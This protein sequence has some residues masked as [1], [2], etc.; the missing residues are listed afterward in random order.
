ML[1]DPKVSLQT[2]P[3]IITQSSDY[4]N[5]QCLHLAHKSSIYKRFTV[6]TAA[7]QTVPLIDS[8]S[9]SPVE[10]RLMHYASNAGLNPS[11]LVTTHT[12]IEPCLPHSSSGCHALAA[13]PGSPPP[14]RC[15]WEWLLRWHHPALN[16]SQGAR[17][18]QACDARLLQVGGCR[19]SP[20]EEDRD[21][22][23]PSPPVL[24]CAC[25]HGDRS[26]LERQRCF[27]KA[28]RETILLGYLSGTLTGFGSCSEDQQHP[29]VHFCATLRGIGDYPATRLRSAGAGQFKEAN[30]HLLFP[31]SP[32]VLPDGGKSRSALTTQLCFSTYQQYK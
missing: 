12:S 20:A 29:S 28:V 6:L 16:R 31:C 2:L 30:F 24:L 4:E 17:R 26:A 15:C 10:A 14:P 25:P 7:Q 32:S 13:P 1:A 18:R 27:G 8:I 21:G 22:A 3:P 9:P 5:D 19:P 11:K 23:E